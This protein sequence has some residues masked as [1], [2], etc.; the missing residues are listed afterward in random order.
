[1]HTGNKGPSLCNVFTHV[2]RN[3]GFLHSDASSC[4]KGRK[5]AITTKHEERVVIMNQRHLVLLVR[6]C[7]SFFGLWE[8][9]Q[10]EWAH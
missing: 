8:G 5:G 2:F 4:D 7:H 10:V 6:A 9:D 1:M 3:V